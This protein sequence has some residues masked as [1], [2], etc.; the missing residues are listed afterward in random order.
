MNLG[1]AKENRLFVINNEKRYFATA[2]DIHPEIENNS[3]SYIVKAITDNSTVLDVGCSYGYLGEWLTKNKNC[4]VYGIDIDEEALGYVK[5]RGYYKDVF[6]LDLDYPQNTKD[7][8]ERFAKLQNIFDFAI[9]ADVLEHLKNPTN[10]LD[11]ISSKLKLGGQVLIS[12]PNIAHMDIILNLLESKFNYSEFGILDNTHLR[13]FTKKSFAEWIKNANE[14]YKDKG[15]KFDAKYLGATTY[16]SEFLVDVKNNHAELYSKILGINNELEI[17]QHIFV[18][19]KVNSFANTYNLDEIINTV[20]Y[21]NA[22]SIIA[23]S[24]SSLENELTFK[25]SHI[26]ELNSKVA[27]LENELES[28]EVEIKNLNNELTNK[29]S[30]IQELNSK[31]DSLENELISVLQ[32]R[33]W[34]YTRPIRKLLHK[35]KLNKK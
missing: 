8:F 16:V 1:N 18:L 9:C 35:L 3:L 7:E 20:N 4:Q 22:F 26:Q 6:H 19:T 17:L 30:Y 23:S 32:S 13:F 24:I 21:P 15:F 34:R 29:D 27:S 5:E 2:D 14:F 25:D 28:R 10:A 31:V 12:I 11:F 33:S